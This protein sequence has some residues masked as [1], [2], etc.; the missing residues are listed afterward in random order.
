M[1]VAL[2]WAVAVAAVGAIVSLFSGEQ[3][4]CGRSVWDR[5][6]VRRWLPPPAT[7][8]PPACQW[9]SPVPLQAT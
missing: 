9:R 5:A 1:A 6:G 3:P 2:G 8:R 4:V 7:R